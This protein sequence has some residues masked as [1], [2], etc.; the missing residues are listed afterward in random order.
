[1]KL[2]DKIV[3]ASGTGFLGQV[4]VKEL[5]SKVNE[6]VILSRE[7]HPDSGNV[8]YVKW[9]A[10]TCG[11]WVEELENCDV[12]INL[13]GK[14]VDCRYTEKNKTEIAAS[15]LYST[16]LLG[17]ALASVKEAPG[18][19]I[20]AS[21]A[22]IYVH[23]ETT[24]MDEY[25]GET[26]ND[27]SMTVCKRWEECFFNCVTPNT[28]KV[29]LRTGLVLGK[30][31]GVFPRLKKIARAGLGGTIG[32]GRQLVNWVYEKDFT[33]MVQWLIANKN[34]EGIYNCVSPEPVSNR[35][36]MQSLRK[37]LGL[38]FG[39]PVPTPLLHVA[40]FFM[41]TEPELV[42]KSRFVIPARALKE[43]FV[44]EYTS[45]DGALTN[46]IQT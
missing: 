28:R 1:M 10:R 34:C 26:G 18:L 32:T 40:A 38:R 30:A 36:F 7:E 13:C 41:R 29:A 20:N 31:G 35:V 43:N 37:A 24:A 11:S 4:L 14:S 17:E 44:F 19:W 23:S 25:Q 27:F 5:K 16:H 15:R 39:L 3:I 46:L 12:L 45:L 2:S 42:L 9:D 33:R 21:S 6:I 22:T 8:R